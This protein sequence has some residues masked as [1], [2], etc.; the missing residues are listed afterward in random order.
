MSNYFTAYE[1]KRSLYKDITP[2]T[3]WRFNSVDNIIFA[4][5]RIDP[6][7]KL[8]WGICSIVADEINIISF[9]FLIDSYHPLKQTQEV[10]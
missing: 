2:G 1:T 3:V 4:V 7:N 6:V 5:Q 9:E 8:A 10:K